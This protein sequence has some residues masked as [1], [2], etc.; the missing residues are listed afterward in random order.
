KLNIT[1]PN[2]EDLDV[3]LKSPTGTEIELFTD[4]GG[5]GDNF[6]NTILDAGASI[7]I[8]DASAPFTGRFLPEG[9]TNVL[10]SF[11]GENPNGTWTLKIEDDATGDTGTLDDWELTIR[12]DAAIYSEIEVEDLSGQIA[13]LNLSLD[14]T[15]QAMENLEVSLLSPGGTEVVLISGGSQSGSNFLGTFDDEATHPVG[16]LTDFDGLGT[17]ASRSFALTGSHND[18]LFVAKESGSAFNDVTIKFADGAVDG[19]ASAFYDAGSKTLT[20][21]VDKG[22]TTANTVISTVNGISTVPFTARLDRTSE[23]ENNGSGVIDWTGNAPEA[24]TSGGSDLNGTWKLKIVDNE[25]NFSG[26]LNNWSLEISTSP[27]ISELEVSG[28]PDSLTDVNVTLNITH[29]HDEHLDVFLFSPSGSGVKLFDDLPGVNFGTSTIDTTL[30]DQAPTAITSGSS[31]YTGTFRPEGRLSAFNGEDPNGTWRLEI[32]DDTG[33]VVGQLNHWSLTFSFKPENVDALKATVAGDV[34]GDGL[35]DLLFS[36]TGFEGASS[37]LG[38]AYLLLGQKVSGNTGKGEV[39]EAI[40]LTAGGSPTTKASAV[41]AFAGDNNNIRFDAKTVGDTY[42][43]V[44]IVFVDDG[45]QS[46]N[47]ASA[48]YVGTTLTIKIDNGVTTAEKVVEEVE[49]SSE[50]GMDVFRANFTV[51]LAHEVIV[52]LERDSAGRFFDASLGGGVFAVGDLNHD[53][54]DDFAV[55]RTREDAGDASGGLL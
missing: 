13:D 9:G 55:S 4:I 50:T 5:S 8:A 45:S 31:P 24:L 19:G 37:S 35:D 42:N 17:A 53:G 7:N 44:N 28:L 46:G 41:F 32:T 27:A 21:T 15:H 52:Q 43:G 23:L 29:S 26:T 10:N 54:Y 36:T 1:H 48:S 11:D 47:T 39:F 30:D 40:G 6:T 20:I 25:G 3:Y 14:I 18:L 16:N 49:N 33:A 34:N 51:S 38:R 22:E 2:V 12:T